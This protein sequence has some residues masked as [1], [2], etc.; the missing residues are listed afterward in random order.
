VGATVSAARRQ[1]SSGGAR[2]EGTS[3]WAILRE[4]VV[5]TIGDAT[6]AD[7]LLSSAISAS[8]LE[9]P[10][11]SADGVVSFAKTHLLPLLR[12]EAGAR[13][14]V[15]MIATLESSLSSLRRAGTAESGRR[16]R[17]DHDTL[18][19]SP[20]APSTPTLPPMRAKQPSITGDERRPVALL[21]GADALERSALARALVQAGLDVRSIDTADALATM[22]ARGD[23]VRL[24]IVDVDRDD[25]ESI[26]AALAE[27]RRDV[28]IVARTSGRGGTL[29][30]ARTA[31]LKIVYSYARHRPP[32][33]VIERIRE[34]AMH[35][36]PASLPSAWP[37]ASE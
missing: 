37:P 24:A 11:T 7:G 36:D 15:A 23:A 29:D 6:H 31:D 35:D 17:D 28:P 27:S 1:S 32:A 8:N 34:C 14:A 16:R 20:L 9:S 33:D 26:F 22:L 21:I 2:G 10:P 30:D 12:D 5:E 13:I 3:A 18:P 19:P 25:A 4:L